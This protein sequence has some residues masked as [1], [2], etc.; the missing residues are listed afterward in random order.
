MSIL[1]PGQ[2]TTKRVKQKTRTQQGMKQ[3]FF[4]DT[5]H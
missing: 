3:K 1:P 5:F 4:S 2:K